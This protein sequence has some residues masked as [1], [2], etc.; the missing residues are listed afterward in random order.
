MFFIL[1]VRNEQETRCIGCYDSLVRAQQ[2]ILNNSG[3]MFEGGYYEYAVI[4]AFGN[5]RKSSLSKSF[6]PNPL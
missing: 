3:D 4:F 1:T 5:S 2:H 6:V